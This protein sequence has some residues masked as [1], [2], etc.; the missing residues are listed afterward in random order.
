MDDLVI[1]QADKGGAVVL[2]DKGLYLRENTLMLSDAF[3]YRKLESN[4]T[5]VFKAKLETLVNEGVSL[6]VL[7]EKQAKF[8]IVDNPRIPIYHSLPKIHKSIFPP[9]MRLIVLGGYLATASH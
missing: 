7:S 3:T 8:I 9:P 1:R 2:L 5:N 4:P 6:G